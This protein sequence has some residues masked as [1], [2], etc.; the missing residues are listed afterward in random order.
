MNAIFGGGVIG[1]A[2]P[3]ESQSLVA[4][5]DTFRILMQRG[6]DARNVPGGMRSRTYSS[7][8]LQGGP[9]E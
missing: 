9:M 5:A 2:I 6:F 4:T 1:C 3:D 8:F 7:F